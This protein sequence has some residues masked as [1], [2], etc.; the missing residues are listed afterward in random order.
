MA[1]KQEDGNWKPYQLPPLERSIAAVF[2]T[3]D[4]GRL[5]KYTYKFIIN[6]MGFI[7]H[8][9]LYGFRS[10]Y[11]DLDEFRNCLQTS[12][13]SGDPNYNLNWADRY[14]VDRDFLKWYGPAYCQS[15]A[16]GIRCIVAVART[17]REQYAML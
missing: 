2:R 4:I 7:A 11:A 14:E 10:T 3:G 5:D 12:E 13:Y 8:Y 9:D 6:N 1:Q 16:A 17:Q 15:V